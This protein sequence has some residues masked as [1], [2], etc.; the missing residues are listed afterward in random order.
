M[1]K[2]F[3]QAVNSNKYE[4]VYPK[5]EAGT[6]IKDESTHQDTCYESALLQEIKRETFNYPAPTA[7]GPWLLSV[8]EMDVLPP[9]VNYEYK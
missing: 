6:Y 5:A 2:E 7:A 3:L 1:K 4:E 9:M 8:L